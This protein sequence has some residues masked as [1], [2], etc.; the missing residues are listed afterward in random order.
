MRMSVA[1]LK[2]KI[3]LSISQNRKPALQQR[4]PVAVPEKQ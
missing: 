3:L 1:K 4:Y 2:T